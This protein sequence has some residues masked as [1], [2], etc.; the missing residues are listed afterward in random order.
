MAPPPAINIIE[1]AFQDLENTITPGDSRLFSSTTLQ[2]VRDAAIGIEVDLAARQKFCNIRRLSPLL[3]G[4]D[5]YSKAIEVLCNGT[6]YLPWIWAPIKLV[7]QLA[8]DYVEAFKTIIDAYSHIAD[9]LPR[10][11][12]LDKTLKDSPGVQYALAVFYA[13]ILRFH[14][15]AYRF[16]KRPN[17]KIFFDSSWGRFQRRFK[18]ILS[19]LARH[20]ELVDT[21]ANAFNIS[22]AH[23]WRIEARNWRDQ[24]IT[25][26]KRQDKQESFLQYQSMLSWLDVKQSEQDDIFNC[27]SE[28]YCPGT[29]DW[30]S[31]NT[32]IT[33][34]MRHQ[35]EQPYLWLKGKPGAGKSVLSTRIVTFLEKAPDTLLL[36]HFCS[37]HYSSSVQYGNILASILHQLLRD[38]D[39]LLAYVYTG[40]ILARK[41]T[42]SKTLEAL[43]LTLLAAVSTNPAKIL[44][45]RIILDGLDEC[46]EDTQQRV[47]NFVGRVVALKVPGARCKV[48]LCSQDAGKLNKMLKKRKSIALGEESEA[49]SLAIGVYTKQRLEKMRLNEFS[50]IDITDADIEYTEATIAKKADGM[51]LWARLVL[52]VLAT[53]AFDGQGMR[54]AVDIIPRELKE[55]YRR[56]WVRIEARFQSHSLEKIRRML[57]WIMFAKRP[58]KK[59]ELRTV[60]AFNEP[61][62]GLER[63]PPEEIIELCKPLIEERKDSTYGFIHGSVPDFLIS[64]QSGPIVPELQARHDQ[65]LACLIYLRSATK[66]FS[67]AYSERNRDLR[68]LKWL[69]SFHLYATHFW[70]D[71]L[72]AFAKLQPSLRL[73]GST[74]FLNVAYDL[75]DILSVANA[76]KESSSLGVSI[77]NDGEDAAGVIKSH[78]VLYDVIKVELKSRDLVKVSSKDTTDDIT[79]S[80]TELGRMLEAYQSIVERLIR[81]PSFPGISPENLAAFKQGHAFSAYTCRFPGCT[82]ATVGFEND[83]LRCDHEVKHTQ[84]LRCTVPDCGYDLPFSSPNAL[85]GHHKRYH[86]PPPVSKAA[87]I[88]WMKGSCYACRDSMV[89]CDKNRPQCTRCLSLG[90]TCSYDAEPV[91][92]LPKGIRSSLPLTD[93]VTRLFPTAQM[94]ETRSARPQA[95]NRQELMRTVPKQKPEQIYATQPPDILTERLQEAQ[96]ARSPLGQQYPSSSPFQP[97]SQGSYASGKNDDPERLGNEEQASHQQRAKANPAELA[98]LLQLFDD[99]KGDAGQ[100]THEYMQQSSIH[101]KDSLPEHNGS[102]DEPRLYNLVQEPRSTKPLLNLQI[103]QVPSEEQEQKK[104]SKKEYRDPVK[105]LTPNFISSSGDSV[106]WSFRTA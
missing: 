99:C 11:D 78:G 47:V 29:C 53:E 95:T 45:V 13:D 21:E 27:L 22:E 86:A 55:F 82:W 63:L 19:D 18:G 92:S 39:D 60:L 33:S 88:G 48:L 1:K 62:N 83:T 84:K 26:I 31:K 77:A 28:A 103:P 9:C 34:W 87:R 51:F 17:W 32:S 74:I 69:H 64:A 3:D 40:Y 73:P 2:G 15:D 75:A 91:I 98:Q 66:I 16:V 5:H 67:P 25:D 101:P 57:S 42:A 89:S 85:K 105:V 76:V 96:L 14:K 41:S 72:L 44:C 50:D 65:S 43:I 68:I 10:F 81:M 100:P 52:D 38:K 54:D 6:P 106:G 90:G 4:L 59:Y 46:D 24:S 37:H 97:E 36:R 61:N 71:H 49:V 35:P 8:S 58:L 7:L 30:I 12:V 94:L 23:K 56:I 70:I 102:R 93:K 79:V 20:A 80:S 104:R